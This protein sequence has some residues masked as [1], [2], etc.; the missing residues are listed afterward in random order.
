MVLTVSVPSQL[1]ELRAVRE[2]VVS[3]AA[4]WHVPFDRG[5]VAL[6]LTE[7][8]TNAMEHGEPPIA[9]TMDWD[10]HRLRVAVSDGSPTVPVHRVP[11]PFDT[12]G[13]GI[14]LLDQAASAWGVDATPTGKAVWFELRPG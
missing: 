1:A 14:W 12:A 3:A 8:L 4:G 10:E 11:A 2:A 7:L 6:L 5:L 9:V 13:R